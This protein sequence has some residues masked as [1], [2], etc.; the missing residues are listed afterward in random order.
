MEFQE[1]FNNFSQAG[2][3]ELIQ[4]RPARLAPMLPVSDVRAIVESGLEGDRYKSNGGNR[5]VTLLQFEHLDVIAACLGKP[6]I[7][8]ASTRRNIA[9][10]GINLLA[11]KGKTFSIGEAVFEYS[12]ECHPCPRMEQNLGHGGYNA[13]RGHGGITAKI[14]ESGL[15][16]AGDQILVR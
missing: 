4:L 11:L 15:I 8:F 2:K 16:R 10:S 1:L 13:M 5:Q 12:G 3:V 7:D 6:Q 14:I 9:V